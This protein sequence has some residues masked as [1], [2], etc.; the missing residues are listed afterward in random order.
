[1]CK[2]SY[3]SAELYRRAGPVKMHTVSEVAEEF[4]VTTETVR[5][6][7]RG[8]LLMA[9]QPAG[10]H[11]SYRIPD[12]AIEVFRNRSQRIRPRTAHA[13]HAPK[14]V[15]RL[16]V[17]QLYRTRIEPVLRETGMSA[18]ELM[19]RMG[20]DSSLVVR[21][22]SFMSDY[23]VYVSRAARRVRQRAVALDA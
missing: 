18:D 9:I 16:D 2:V 1:M 14:T 23:S 15:Q 22:P 21:F 7:I 4:G 8:R 20:H 5:A 19:R 17:D 11:G 12:S 6:W 10:E 13:T 3:C